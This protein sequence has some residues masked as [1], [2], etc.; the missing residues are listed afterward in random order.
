MIHTFLIAIILPILLSLCFSCL[1]LRSS[2]IYHRYPR[3]STKMEVPFASW[4]NSIFNKNR[5]LEIGSEMSM[6]QRSENTKNN[7]DVITSLFMLMNILWAHNY[8]F[9]TDEAYNFIVTKFLQPNFNFI[10]VRL[11]FS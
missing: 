10:G 1:I 11:W 8:V 7:I 3:P 9:Y 2:L 4:K 6:F 5:I